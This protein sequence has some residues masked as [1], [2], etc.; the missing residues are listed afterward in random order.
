MKGQSH[1]RMI[2]SS[3]CKVQN[4]SSHWLWSP[5]W[6][7]LQWLNSSER[8]DDHSPLSSVE[9]KIAWNFMYFPAYV[10]IERCSSKESSGYNSIQ[11]FPYLAPTVLLSSDRKLNMM[12]FHIKRNRTEVAHLRSVTT[13]RFTILRYGA[14]S[15]VCFT[16]AS[17]VRTSAMLVLQ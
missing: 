5:H 8:E 9:V 2:N 6:S 4:P 11:T 17:Q 15:G 13:Y 3:T 12:P 10:F 7:L 1:P 14:S 16:P